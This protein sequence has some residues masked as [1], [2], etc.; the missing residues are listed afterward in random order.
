MTWKKYPKTKPPKKSDYIVYIDKANS[1]IPDAINVKYFD[2]NKWHGVN[3]SHCPVVYW[4]FLPKPPKD[5]WMAKP[6]F[7]LH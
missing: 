2:G 5:S 3:Q 7:N 1:N 4:K 6:F